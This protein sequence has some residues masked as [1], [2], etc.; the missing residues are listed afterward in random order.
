PN[1]GAYQDPNANRGQQ[2]NQNYQGQNYN[3]NQG[4]YNQNT[5][6]DPMLDNTPLTLKE[7]IITLILVAIPCVGI[8]MLIMWAVSKAGNINR[9]RFAQA[10]LIIGAAA[11]IIYLLIMLIF[12]A[13]FMTMFGGGYYY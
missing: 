5:S 12:G 11:V 10:Q 2:F 1:A 3:Y 4:S 13:S 6:M 7:W 8:V 9:K